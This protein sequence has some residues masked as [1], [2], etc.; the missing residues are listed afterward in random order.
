M[1]QH[2]STPERQCRTSLGRNLLE[3]YCDLEDHCCF[4]QA[5]KC[6]LPKAWRHENI[7]ARRELAR[8][9][10]PHLSE[11]ERKIS[12]GDPGLML[13]LFKKILKENST[14]RQTEEAAREIKGKQQT[15]NP[16]KKDMLYIQN[17]LKELTESER[18][19]ELLKITESGVV[20]N[21]TRYSE[22]C[23][24]LPFTPCIFHF[25]EAGLIRLTFLSLHN[26]L[27]V[28]LYG[29]LREAGLRV[30]SLE[31]ERDTVEYYAFE[32]CRTFAAVEDAFGDDLGVLLP[33]FNPLSM[34]G[35]SC[36]PDLRMWLWHKLVHFEALGRQDVQPVKKTF[37]V[38]WGM[39]ELLTT[40]FRSKTLLEGQKKTLRVHD[41]ELAAKIAADD[42]GERDEESQIVPYCFRNATR[43]AHMIIRS[44]I[45][46]YLVS[47]LSLGMNSESY[48]E[49]LKWSPRSRNSGS[50]YCTYEMIFA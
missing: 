50:N 18:A 16:K 5:K 7:R 35:F 4:L 17:S 45:Y 48:A 43:M 29:P 44:L 42:P 46:R 36:P 2:F 47:F 1:F 11:D 49:S 25:P 12:L 13:D 32:I 10:L 31:K 14:V 6:L 37:S 21:Q 9:E 8:I 40:G 41:I 33:C 20:A 30:E 28:V 39:P 38:F 22:C 26:F 23:P 15:R 19:S 34:A 24:P 3:W 27:H